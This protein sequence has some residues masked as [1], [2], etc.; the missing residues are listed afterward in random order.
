MIWLICPGDIA[1]QSSL[2]TEL[3]NSPT[4]LR[5]LPILLFQLMLLTID[6]LQ[7]NSHSLL[8]D[9]MIFFKRVKTEETIIVPVVPF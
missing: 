1:H 3:W 2:V 9:R 8:C 5:T 4:N 6:L 7:F